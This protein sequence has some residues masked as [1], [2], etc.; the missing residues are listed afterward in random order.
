MLE[1]STHARTK[2]KNV[3]LFSPEKFDHPHFCFGVASSRGEER[4]AG[5]GGG[6]GEGRVENKKFDP[7]LPHSP[8]PPLGNLEFRTKAIWCSEALQNQAGYQCSARAPMGGARCGAV[9]TLSNHLHLAPSGS[10]AQAAPSVLRDCVRA[11]HV[12][13]A[14]TIDH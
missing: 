13:P 5:K 12:V 6:H 9:G 4:G 14:G 8:P 1:T 10:A 2:K 7:H 11:Q 3:L